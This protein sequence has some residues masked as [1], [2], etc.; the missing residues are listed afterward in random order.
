M[1]AMRNHCKD[2]VAATRSR[3]ITPCPGG[4][5]GIR[6]GLKIPRP[7]G[8]V[9]STPTPGTMKASSGS[10][11]SSSG[12]VPADLSDVSTP[13]HLLQFENVG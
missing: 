8:H 10:H 12:S 3:I 9:G 1:A 2:S 5:T 4:E 6:K 11:A 13:R 7:Q